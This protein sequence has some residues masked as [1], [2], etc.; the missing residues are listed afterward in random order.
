MPD[1]VDYYSEH[2]YDVINEILADVYKYVYQ[3]KGNLTDLIKECCNQGLNVSKK[4]I[5]VSEKTGIQG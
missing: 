3:P 4:Y 5:C 1:S 2:E